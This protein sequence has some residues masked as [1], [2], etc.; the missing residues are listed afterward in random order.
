[1][2]QPQE[3]T[4][5]WVDHVPVMKR[6]GDLERIADGYGDDGSGGNVLERIDPELQQATDARVLQYEHRAVAK[7]VFENGTGA[8]AELIGNEGRVPTLME[9]LPVV[10]RRTCRLKDRVVEFRD[11]ARFPVAQRVVLV[12]FQECLRQAATQAPQH[13]GERGRAAAVHASNDDAY[14]LHIDFPRSN[15]REPQSVG[16][17]SHVCGYGQPVPFEK[18]TV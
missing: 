1:M 17:P 13:S 7:L 5:G 12:G 11:F 3:Q 18:R 14:P 2:S 10:P 9:R 15:V 4:D 16:Q 8:D 6:R